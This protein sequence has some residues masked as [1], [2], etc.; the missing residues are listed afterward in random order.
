MTHQGDMEIVVACLYDSTLLIVRVHQECQQIV[1]HPQ[2]WVLERKL[3]VLYCL[4]RNSQNCGLTR[5]SRSSLVEVSTVI[6]QVKL[7]E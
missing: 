4:Y 1:W 6:S 3:D 2:S 5:A 7:G